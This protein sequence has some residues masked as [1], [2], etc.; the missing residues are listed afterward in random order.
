MFALPPM[1]ALTRDLGYFLAP[2]DNPFAG[3]PAYYTRR[4]HP[5]G[6]HCHA[7]PHHTDSSSFIL[8]PCPPHVNSLPEKDGS[9]VRSD[10]PTPLS[11]N[12]ALS[13]ETP[14]NKGLDNAQGNP[15]RVA[16]QA[17][18]GTAIGKSGPPQEPELA[19][20]D[21]WADFAGLPHRTPQPTIP[22]AHLM[23][24]RTSF[25][26]E[27]ELPGIPKSNVNVQWEGGHI[28][29]V[30]ANSTPTTEAKDAKLT[31]ETNKDSKAEDASSTK[32]GSPHPVSITT[33]RHYRRRFDFP[34]GIT[35]EA[36]QARFQDGLL[37]VTVP[38]TS[39]AKRTI[40][41]EA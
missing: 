31:T 30:Q 28:L 18:N 2:F 21:P 41:V 6:R 32:A 34:A 13:P 12:S 5:F 4:G 11:P 38:K 24:D 40:P 20:L 10:G 37:T 36:I 7:S 29:V 33:A 16:T 23:E 3:R 27:I 15:T 26:L 17:A 22:E 1:D 39:E 9:T 35:P 25:Y 8:V 14:E 19:S